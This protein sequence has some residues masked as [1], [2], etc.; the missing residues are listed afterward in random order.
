MTD[1]STGT[2][3]TSFTFFFNLSKFVKQDIGKKGLNGALGQ[4]C[5]HIIKKSFCHQVVMLKARGYSDSVVRS[6]AETR[7]IQRKKKEGRIES[8]YVQKCMKSHT[9]N[10]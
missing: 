7:K 1:E 2:G 6:G 8:L 4:S 3:P 5:L 9:E 10:S